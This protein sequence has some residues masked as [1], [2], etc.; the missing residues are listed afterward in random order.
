MPKKTVVGK[1]LNSIFKEWKTLNGDLKKRKQEDLD[2][3]LDLARRATSKTKLRNGID[4]H[5]SIVDVRLGLS[6]DLRF[7]GELSFRVVFKDD[8]S[9]SVSQGNLESYARNP[10]TAHISDRKTKMRQLVD[11][12]IL[13]FRNVTVAVCAGCNH[14]LDVCPGDVDHIEGYEFSKLLARFDQAVAAGELEDSDKSWVLFHERHAKLQ[15]LCKPCHAQKTEAA[16][17]RARAGTEE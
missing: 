11:P 13:A 7:P 16:R 5:G 8:H 3:V 2:F 12:Q 6:D 4:E 10:H 9:C 15:R 1:R 14:P 17:K